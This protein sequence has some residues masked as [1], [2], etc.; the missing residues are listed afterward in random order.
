MVVVG[1]YLVG[2]GQLSVGGLVACSILGGRVLGPIGQ[3][4]NLAFQWHYARNALK[5]LN[6][7]MDLPCDGLADGQPVKREA[8]AA[9]LSTEGVAYVYGPDLPPAIRLG[10]F[11]IRPGDRVGIVGPTG[12]GKS[13]LLKLLSGLYK[14]SQGRLMLDGV[15]MA[16]MDVTQLRQTVGFLPQDI[17]LFQ[18]SLRHNLT[19]GLSRVSDDDILEVCRLTGLNALVERHP[20][21]LDLVLSEGGRGL[22]GGQL[23]AVALART[24]LACPRLLLLDEPTAAMDQALEQRIIA[25]I[26]AKATPEQAVVWVTHKPAL[27][28]AATRL[29]VI[30]QGRIVMDGPRDAILQK[31]GGPVTAER[32]EG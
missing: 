9:R 11:E 21:G 15:D 24:L 23:Q 31:V 28:Q 26:L 1:A 14:P 13:T 10:G 7:I 6:V 12:S 30:D 29:V 5:N 20:R 17:R 18:G 25:G 22:S 27:I 4:V 19:L 32:S 16:Q 8:I 3:M 2:K